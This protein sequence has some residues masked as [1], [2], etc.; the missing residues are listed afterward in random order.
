VAGVHASDPFCNL[1]DLI[2]AEMVEK[3]IPSLA[4]AVARDG[5]ILW[6]EGFGWADREMRTPAT[7]HTMYSLASISKPI[8]ATGIM[9]LK[10]EGKLDLERPIDDYL[11]AAKLRAGI[12]N[13]AD[14][15]VRR[16]AGH[17]AGLP[18]HYQF[19]YEDE[20]YRR[21]P[22]EETI[23]RYGLLITPPG[24][25]MH[26]SNLGYGLLDHIITHVSGQSYPEFMQREVF[27]PLGMTRSSVDIGPGLEAY[28]AVRY[29]DD[30]L[31]YP[32]YDFD[33]PGGSAVFCSAHDLVRFGM[34]HC[35]SPLPDQKRILS[36]ADLDA[37]QAPAEKGAVG[38]SYAIGWGI[39]ADECGFRVVSHGGGMG[40]V[41]TNLALIPSEKLVVA[42]LT[43]TNTEFPFRLTQ[44]IFATLLP[45]YAEKWAV[46]KAKR[47]KEGKKRPKPAPEFKPPP[48]LIGEWKGSVQTY[49]GEIP[50]TLW[51]KRSGDIHAQLGEQLKTLV[52]KAEYKD[53]H[54]GGVMFGDLNTPD[55]NRR[56]YL[57]HLDL[58]R[59]GEVLNGAVIAISTHTDRT[60]DVLR[61]RVGNALSHWAELKKQG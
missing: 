29:S 53:D 41:N 50:F 5:A 20:P 42:A 14:A 12:G 35:K 58:K 61:R 16:V 34:F 28:A 17:T 44:E 4:V 6:E 8:T 55:A 49:Q 32:F 36:D 43:N 21:P 31:R 38:D 45:T 59:R 48:E 60:G 3:S 9:L 19:F 37:M 57:L 13:A 54:L 23:R 1:R 25:R 51:F 47:E 24:E 39:N 18:L 46:A 15:T 33:H 10:A 52:N 22:M 7:E 27:L 30:G 26:Y 56:P 11:G 2:R 40:G